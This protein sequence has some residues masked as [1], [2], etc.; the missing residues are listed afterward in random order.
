MKR[1]KKKRTGS[2]IFKHPVEIRA[3]QLPIK[4][5]TSVQNLD[6]H[7]L[8]RA[9]RA[10]IEL[11]LVKTSC[12]E[13]IVRAIVRNGMVTE[14]RVDPCSSKKSGRV[15]SEVKGMLD[16][17]RKKFGGTRQPPL[18]FP[19]PVSKMLAEDSLPPGLTVIT[20]F[21]MCFLS[22]CIDCCQQPS[23]DWICGHLTIDTTTGPYKPGPEE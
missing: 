5:F 19:I 6:V 22:W 4:Y 15:S 10:E 2:I 11:G 1:T 16:A 23:G 20:C 7:K 14:V 13:Q 12:C 8:S 17:A 3:R 9:K 21:Q 18:R